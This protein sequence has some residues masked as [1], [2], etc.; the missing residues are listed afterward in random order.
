MRKRI[1]SIALAFVLALS[2]AVT[3]TG[4]GNDDYPVEVAN[5]TIESEPK[6]IVVLDAST[7]DII[8]YTGYDIK[9]VGR[10]DEVNQDWLSVVPSVGSQTSPDVDKIKTYE[11]DIVF[12]SENLDKTVKESLEKENIQVITMSQAKTPKSLETNYVT[13]GKILGGKVTGSNKGASSYDDLISNMEKVKSSVKSQV[14]SD[15]LYTVCYLYYED[16]NLKLMTSGTYGDMLLGY[17]GAV[18][19]AVNIDENKVDVNTLKVANPNFIFYA[20]DAT[21]NAIK[22]DAVLSKLTA[23]TGGKTLMVT[24][25]EMNRQG[26]TALDTLQKMVDFMYPSLKKST[27]TKDEASKTTATTAAT[28]PSA[29]T[30]SLADKYKINLDKL[31]LKYEDENDNVKIMQ[32]RLYD[33]GYVDDKENITGYYGD[34]S[35]EAVENFQTKNG[36]KATGNADNATLVKMFDSNAVKN[37]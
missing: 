21:L 9:M 14:N 2:V 22:A 1:V 17:T 8:S 32:Q 31:S 6:N 23:V 29:A 15:I 28:T 35:K 20:D 34:I 26:K 19:A 18:N 30:T 13:L 3:F 10:S 7:A 33:L 37:G 5:I 36:I 24:F 16:N 27:S 25:D 12:A 11:T 4:C